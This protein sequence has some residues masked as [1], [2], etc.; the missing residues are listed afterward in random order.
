MVCA[1]SVAH[2]QQLAGRLKMRG[3]EAAAVSASTAQGTR[4]HLIK[5]FRSGRLRVITNYGVLTTGFD[6][7]ETR[8][9]YVA[10]PTFSQSLYMQMIGRGLRGPRNGGK[11]SCLIVDVKDKIERFAGTFAYD[12]VGH[13]WDES[14]GDDAMDAEAWAALDDD[15]EG[16]GE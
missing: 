15:L 13:L 12:E 4:H 3:I 2:A 1:S 11:D 6:A 5:E 8:A 14:A 9:I 7:P 16:D 10:R